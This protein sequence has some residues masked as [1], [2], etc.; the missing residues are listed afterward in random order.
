MLKLSLVKE[1]H[2][3]L[4]KIFVEMKKLS[5]RTF[6]KQTAIA[7]TV[8]P[9]INAGALHAMNETIPFTLAPLPYKYD[10]LEPFIDTLTMQIHH[11]KHH[12]AY[13]D[14]LNA[15][16][17]DENINAGSIEDLLANVSKYKP[18]VRNNGG[19]HYNHNLFWELMMPTAEKNIPNKLEVAINASF[20]NVDEMKKQFND[21]ALKRFGSGWAWLVDIGTNLVICSTANQD[22]PLM[23]LAGVKGKPLLCLDVWEHAYYLKYQNKRA[24]YIAAWWNTVNWNVVAARM[25]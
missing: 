21:A 14:K 15:A 10:A 16:I 5:R 1:N 8:L 4:Q 2:L 23:D 18:A 13:V 11:D 9:L 17:K 22:N 24:D 6:V 3:L 25:K 19:G 7:A 20:G 12:Q